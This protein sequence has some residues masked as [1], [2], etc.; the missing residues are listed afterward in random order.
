MPLAGLVGT[1]AACGWAK[2]E[3]AEVRNSYRE[4]IRLKPARR[5]LLVSI[6]LAA[7][8]L[9]AVVAQAEHV[10]SEKLLPKSTLLFAHVS[11]VPDTIAAFNETNLGRMFH[12]PQIRPF[13]NGV[14]DTANKMLSQVKDRTG[15]SI[16]D[17]AKLHR[18]K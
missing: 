1:L 14:L 18:A 7:A 12:D 11:S 3:P 5:R 8:M 15:M 16:E 10:A 9:P 2:I 13:M 6:C 17:L 4:R